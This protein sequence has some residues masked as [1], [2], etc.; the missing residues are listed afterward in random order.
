M[1]FRIAVQTGNTT[2]S[3][4]RV[5]HGQ[6]P[7]A[8]IFPHT[9][10][11]LEQAAYPDA[12]IGRGGH[13]P[14]EQYLVA[15]GIVQG[16]LHEF[17]LPIPLQHTTS[18]CAYPE[19]ALGIGHRTGDDIRGQAAV[20]FREMH[21]VAR[22]VPPNKSSSVETD[23]QAALAVLGDGAHILESIETSID[24]QW[25][26]QFLPDD[27]SFS[28]SD[29]HGVA[30]VQVERIHMNALPD[31]L[32]LTLPI[33]YRYSLVFRSYPNV[34]PAV[35]SKRGQYRILQRGESIG[36]Q[37]CALLGVIAIQVILGR[38]SRVEP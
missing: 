26:R 10:N 15:F 19:T 16:I 21:V 33:I 24:K 38:M 29:P 7:A 5:L 28:G 6:Q 12:A 17:P 34:S 27:A 2:R 14:H 11:P 35:V 25:F 31:V 3:Q 18:K 30:G 36:V 23:P 9:E 1:V 32:H 22:R 4:F 8:A 20:L 13:A 37:P